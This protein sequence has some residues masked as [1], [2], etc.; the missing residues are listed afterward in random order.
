M[1]SKRIGIKARPG[2][3]SCGIYGLWMFLYPVESLLDPMK[4]VE[5]LEIKDD[6]IF[7]S[8]DRFV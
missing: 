1:S 2:Y 5:V 3:P 7:V 6:K 8:E 4:M